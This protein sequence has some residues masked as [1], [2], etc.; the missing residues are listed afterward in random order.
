MDAHPLLA[1]ATLKKQQDNLEVDQV[2]EVL[3]T[4]ALGDTG[5][6]KY[7]GPFATTEVMLCYTLY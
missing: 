2:A 3:G 6:V 5:E 7:F 1:E 4:M